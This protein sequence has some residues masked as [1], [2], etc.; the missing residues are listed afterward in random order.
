MFILFFLSFL[1]KTYKG[2]KRGNG[3]KEEAYFIA[4]SNFVFNI[5][6]LGITNA[7]W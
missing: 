2:K 1:K 7:T 6:A 4:K 5:E 3:S